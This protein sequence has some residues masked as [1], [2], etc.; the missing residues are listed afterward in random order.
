MATAQWWLNVVHQRGSAL[1][2]LNCCFDPCFLL[3]GQLALLRNDPQDALI[4]EERFASLSLINLIFKHVHILR[5]SFTALGS[6]ITGLLSIIG[7]PSRHQARR[8]DRPSAALPALR[9]SIPQN[10]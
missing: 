7:L 5:N 6:S 8:A 3:V 4:V 2:L 1:G 10:R 9:H